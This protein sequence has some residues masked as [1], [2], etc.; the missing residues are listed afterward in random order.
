MIRQS[1]E[2]ELIKYS[3]PFEVHDTAHKQQI[4]AKTQGQYK[5]ALFECV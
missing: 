1:T 4:K 5:Q 3:T 2:A